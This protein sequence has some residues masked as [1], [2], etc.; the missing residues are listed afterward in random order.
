[1]LAAEASLVIAVPLPTLPSRRPLS[2]ARASRLGGL[3]RY[4]GWPF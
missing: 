3:P 4:G 1:V 2:S